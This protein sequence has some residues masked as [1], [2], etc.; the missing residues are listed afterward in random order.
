[1]RGAVC[2]HGNAHEAYYVKVVLSIL[3]LLPKVSLSVI[4]ERDT[5]H[6]IQGRNVIGIPRQDSAIKEGQDKREAS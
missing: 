3:F 5:F 4:P 6:V 1:M 2:M